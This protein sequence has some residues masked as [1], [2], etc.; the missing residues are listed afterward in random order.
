[1]SLH[2]ASVPVFVQILDALSTILTK[3]ETFAEQ[4]KVAPEVMLGL[5][6]S[7]DMFALTRQVQVACDFAKNT[8]GRLAGADLP[9]F[10][11][12]E[13]TFA[14]LQERIAKT[15][16]YVLGLQAKAFDGAESRM[17]QFPMRGKPH[18]MRGDAYL[19]SFALP[20]FY[21][22]AT[23]AYAILRANGVELGKGDYMGKVEGLKAVG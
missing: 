8:S 20:N 12:E 18:E 21:F 19:N 4:K 17:I 13:K 7:P 16:A 22:H 10:A 23:A 1:M 11:D 3:A 5:R 15:K 14:E 2:A 6:L 9:K